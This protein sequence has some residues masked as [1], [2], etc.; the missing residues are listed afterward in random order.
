[1]QNQNFDVII[2]DFTNK[3]IKFITSLVNFFAKLLNV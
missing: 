3:Q 1:M 2:V